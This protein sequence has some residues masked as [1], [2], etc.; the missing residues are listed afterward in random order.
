MIR[1]ILSAKATGVLCQSSS[2]AG[3]EVLNGCKR[4]PTMRTENNVTS[5][6]WVICIT[7]SA[8]LAST[9]C[10]A[11]AGGWTSLPACGC[12]W[13]YKMHLSLVTS[14]NCRRVRRQEPLCSMKP[15]EKDKTSRLLTSACQ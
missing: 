13:G 15:G 3:L 10:G 12:P 14:A 9:C 8:E 4:D 6:T 2:S 5:V 7:P 1:F 11:G